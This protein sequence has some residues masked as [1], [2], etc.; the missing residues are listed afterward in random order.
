MS[1]T[2]QLWPIGAALLQFPGTLPDGTP[3]QDAP[4]EAWARVFREVRAA[5]FDHVDITDSWLKPGDLSRERLDELHRTIKESGLGVTAISAIRRSVIDPDPEAALDSLAYSLRTVEAAAE[6][7]IGVV[8]IGLHRALAPAQERALW[9]WHEPGATD[10]AG[11]RATWELAVERIRSIGDRGAELGVQISLEMYEDTYLGT[12]DSAVALVRDIDHPS[13]GL[14]PDLG[15]L[16][17][18][19]RP[20]E[21]WES[22]L[23]KTLPHANYWHVKNY[24]RDYD[25]ATG[26][27]FTA[28]AP[29]ETGWISYRRAIEIAL[30]HGFNGPICV[31][32]YGGD[33]LSVSATNRDY[34]RRIL[35]AKLEA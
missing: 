9:F 25:P 18:L 16:I 11:D 34:L 21:H 1:Y 22:M 12:A 20:V 32:H 13:V 6:L 33:G 19:H 26:A 3:V 17:R 24:L 23:A 5:G 10:P 29:L 4:T 7:E 30:E 27:Y 28:P 8:S 31:E 2:A 35:A 15:N 14:N